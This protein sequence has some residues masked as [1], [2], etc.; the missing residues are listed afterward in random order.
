MSTREVWSESYGRDVSDEEA[1]EI[2]CNMRDLAIAMLR[3]T[4][5]LR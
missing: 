3:A 5:D 2:L 4:G 1:Q